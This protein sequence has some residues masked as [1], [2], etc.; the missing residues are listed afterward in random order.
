[1]KLQGC[2]TFPFLH[3]ISIFLPFPL[4]SRA[5][6]SLLELAQWAGFL[7]A[8][9]GHFPGVI[10]PQ[11]EHDSTSTLLSHSLAVCIFVRFMAELTIKKKK[12]NKLVKACMKFLFC[13]NVPL[14]Q[15]YIWSFF[16]LNFFS[17]HQTF[18][19]IQSFNFL[20]RVSAISLT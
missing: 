5:H 18:C 9:K 20:A 2:L 4:C 14:N 12:K 7:W 16:I 13:L 6:L 17:F 15:T 1:M 3:F 11:T 8:K 19:Q 10:R